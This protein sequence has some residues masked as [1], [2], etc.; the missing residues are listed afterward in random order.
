MKATPVDEWR[1]RGVDGRILVKRLRRPEGELTEAEIGRLEVAAEA[2][3]H[4]DAERRPQRRSSSI[5][6]R[7]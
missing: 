6:T 7:S 3:A 5:T 4:R 2:Q 1:A